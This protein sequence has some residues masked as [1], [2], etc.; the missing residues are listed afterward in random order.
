[1]GVFIKLWLTPLLLMFLA[2]C[3]EPQDQT[4]KEH[5]RSYLQALLVEEDWSGWAEYFAPNASINGSSF[6]LQI[7][8][9][10]ATGLHFSFAD[11]TVEIDMQV[12]EA[13]RVATGFTFH[14]IHERPFNDQPATNAPIELPGFVID[15]FEGG[16][17]VESRMLLDVWGLSQR[18]AVAGAGLNGGQD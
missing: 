1:M 14:G 13:D 18:T 3:S 2:G 10:T 11:L 12:A 5:V 8:R 6:S 16:R 9:G 17:I 15:R 7:M 4:N